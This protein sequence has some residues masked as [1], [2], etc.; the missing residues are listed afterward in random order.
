MLFHD[1]PKEVETCIK[2]WSRDGFV[3]LKYIFD[4]AKVLTLEGDFDTVAKKLLITFN[5][6]DLVIQKLGLAA[7]SG[8][9]E[10]L[11]LQ[12]YMKDHDL[13]HT[14][15][16]RIS[17]DD[18]NRLRPM[19]LADPV[20]FIAEKIRQEPY[21]HYVPGRTIGFDSSW[22]INEISESSRR[23]KEFSDSRRSD[24]AILVGNGPSLK[25]VD[26]E[27]FE[28]QDVF[29]SNYAIKNQ[30]LNK[31]AKG[32]AV[33]NYLVAEQEPYHF[34]M[35]RHWR[36]FP[37][38]LGNTFSSSE[39]N[40]FLNAV[41]GDLSFSTNVEKKI[42]W[43][44][45][46]SFF[47]LQILY[48]AGYRKIL[49]TGFDNSYKQS[50]TA[51]EGDLIRQEK[52]DENHFD[53]SYFKGKVWQAADTD[54]MEE[55]YILS[56]KHFELD[57][58]EIVNCTVGGQLEVFRRARLQDELPPRKV[59]ALFPGAVRKPKVAVVTAFWP[60]DAKATENHWRLLNRLGY[61]NAD[62]IHLY[63]NSAN[64]LPL[65][66]L[67]RVV[68]ADIDS[69]Y[70]VESKKP[71]PAGPNLV[72]VH[73]VRMLLETGYTHFFW[74]EP[75]C[76]PTSKDWLAPFLERLAQYP[77][78][79]IHGT[80]GGTSNPSKPIWK[81]HFAGCSLY[82]LEKLSQ[83]D[84]KKYLA[85]DLSISF[86][87]WLSVRLGYIELLNIN[88]EDQHNTIIYGEDRYNWRALRKPP[89]LVYGMFEHW[90]P[91]KFLSPE[92]LEERLDWPGFRLY[93]AIKDPNLLY[94]V[95]ARQKP[96]VS[97]VVINYNNDKYLH[98]AI[99]SAL[100]QEI[101]NVDY[102]VIVVD[103]GSTDKSVEV[104]K[105]FGERIKPILLNHGDL[106]PNFNQQRGL[107]TG[108][109]ASQGDI[110]LFLDG[111][112]TFAP[113]RVASSCRMFE[114]IEVV[115]GQHLL[116]LTDED[117]KSLGGVCKNFPSENI[118]PRTYADQGRVNFFQPTSGLAFRRSY[119]LSQKWL[120]R[121]D[122]HDS[123]WMDV[124]ISRFAP[125]FGT[126]YSSNTEQGTWRRH[127]NSDSIRTDNISERVKRHEAWFISIADYLGIEDIT[128]EWME[129]T[130]P[131]FTIPK[132][133]S[134]ARLFIL[135][136]SGQLLKSPNYTIS[137]LESDPLLAK[138][139][140]ECLEI[141]SKNELLKSYFH[142]SLSLAKLKITSKNH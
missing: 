139:I 1:N 18:F 44:S 55:T 11:G 8:N 76:V 136:L 142:R 81:N 3:A 23:L 80:G 141:L 107:R 124:R 29:I 128:F 134:Q 40:I 71:H 60:G 65:N 39:Q 68:C 123:T 16:R 64:T 54:K 57:G 133:E 82:S 56:K 52:N 110:V 88:N 140:Q 137:K 99:S 33:T 125:F 31:Y 13:L 129:A 121:P 17:S 19:L 58:R 113:T 15:Y 28:G 66:T 35:G 127:A 49:M 41:G 70:P 138:K 84:W 14:H 6:S 69:I 101:E 46:V 106:N 126:I 67:P 111:D 96:S 91:E 10:A 122:E 78:E 27:L 21:P 7:Q 103:D 72:F 93:H 98:E 48:H 117:G 20:D 22:V 109:E 73:T 119:L 114:K 12:Q 105:G 45:T 132:T 42:F 75:D 100:N 5:A 130:P 77:D 108:I 97:T 95:Y 50:K 47:W 43:H 115:I 53:A 83:V 112:D 25:S 59:F 37:L 9:M 51:K 116:R 63:K 87:I 38:W 102:E 24:T 118:T 131:S 4:A 89:T 94:K 92:Q 34:Q 26:F 30:A 85:S 74:M 36:F 61:R 32:V 120:M 2:A 90:R 62:H 79:P 135:T 104:I 86:D